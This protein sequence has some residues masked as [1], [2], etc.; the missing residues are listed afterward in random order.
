MF[1]WL[2]KKQRQIRCRTLL[3]RTARQRAEQLR[4]SNP[5]FSETEATQLASREAVASLRAEGVDP[6][7]LAEVTAWSNRFLAS[8]EPNIPEQE[9]ADVPKDCD[10]AMTAIEI[11]DM[12]KM[13]EQ[14][15][16]V[17][18]KAAYYKPELLEVLYPF[19]E[20][21]SLTTATAL[22]QIAPSLRSY[23]EECSPGGEFYEMRRFLD[24]R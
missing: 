18:G 16:A 20:N 5:T 2:Y 1:G 3:G 15:A 10:L 11:K 6:A 14:E 22:L 9:W 12:L 21:P 17:K 13:A 19:I 4:R 7:S 24:E 23:F 8:T